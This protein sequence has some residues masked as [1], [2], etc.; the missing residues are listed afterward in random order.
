MEN[1]N[2]KIVG[3]HC[4]SCA[5]NIEKSIKKKSGVARASVNYANNSAQVEFDPEKI[6]PEVIGQAVKEAGDYK[7]LDDTEDTEDLAIVKKTYKK[8]LGAAILTVPLFLS[9]FFDPSLILG[10]TL[11]MVLMAVLTAIVVFVFGWQFHR[12]MFLQLKRW[13][14]NMDSLISIGTMAAFFYSL[15]AV[16]ADGHVY[17][18][19]AAVIITLILLGKYFEEKS[20]GR[21]ST[22]IKQL[23]SLGAKQATV[24]EQDQVIKKDINQIK[25]GDIVLVKPGEKIPLDSSIIEGETSVDESMLTGESIPVDK[26]AGDM[27][28]GATINNQGVIKIKVEKIGQDT[29]LSHII[30]LIEQAQSSKA[31]IQKLV[32]KISGIFVPIVILIALATFIVWFFA[33]NAGLE[34]SLLNAVAVLVIACPCALGLAT[35][36]AIMVGSGKGAGSGILIKDSQSLEIAHKVNV[37]VF[38]KTGTL[39]QG[40]P[41]IV[42]IKIQDDV[43][44]SQAMMLLACSLEAGSEHSLAVAFANYAREN[45]LELRPA[46]Q[47]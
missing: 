13:Q 5:V 39:T 35:P 42:D 33:L 43:L 3:M 17:F 8:F 24:I 29:V 47:I 30:R 16:F 7:I 9:M 25:I 38:D 14:A 34:I 1:I 2:L 26:K 20:K 45:K 10:M 12:G 15:Y 44:S 31:P 23:L 40:R 22:A 4:A 46:K 18:E 36:T 21:A 19:I 28:Y 6:S 32:D 27:V 37:L 41:T 11:S